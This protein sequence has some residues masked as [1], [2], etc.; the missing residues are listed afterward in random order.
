[1][2]ARSGKLRMGDRLVRV[3]GTPLAG[4]THREAVS[5]LL[6]PGPSLCLSVRHDPL[7]DDFQVRHFHLLQMPSFL[8][9][10]QLSRL[11]ALIMPF[12]VRF[13]KVSAKAKFILFYLNLRKIP[14][15]IIVA[16]VQFSLLIFFS[17]FTVF[18]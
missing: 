12:H 3:N 6:Q 10:L 14:F 8:M 17:D 2:A 16:S 11:T 15:A 13:I 1:M 18:L 7:P 9:G 4:V 5:L